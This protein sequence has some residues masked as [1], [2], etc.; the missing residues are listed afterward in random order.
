[1]VGKPFFLFQISY[2]Y[3][4]LIGAI[5]TITVG[6][7]INQFALISPVC[8]YLLPNDSEIDARPMEIFLKSDKNEEN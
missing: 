8:H 7:I 3:Y 2:Y 4:C 6:L 5:V 1:M